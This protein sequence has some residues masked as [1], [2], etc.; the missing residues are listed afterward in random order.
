[1]QTNE[2]TICVVKMMFFGCVC[3]QPLDYWVRVH[4]LKSLSDGGIL[5][6]DDRLSDVTDD[7]EQVRTGRFVVRPFPLNH[8][9]CPSLL[10]CG[11][12]SPGRRLRPG[13]SARWTRPL[14][15]KSFVPSLQ[16]N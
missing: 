12:V 10:Q 5:D 11:N 9:M 1:M 4:S 2:T 13:C 14:W 7:R 6:F 15:L 3:L 8:R 16:M